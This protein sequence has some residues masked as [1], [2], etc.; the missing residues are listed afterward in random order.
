MSSTL[1]DHARRTGLESL[2]GSPGV[3]GLGGL[4]LTVAA[5]LALF[6]CALTGSAAGV[7][8]AAVVAVV[9]DV[10]SRF[11]PTSPWDLDRP[12]LPPP[13]RWMTS[14]A[15]VLVLA[16]RTGG[17]TGR[18]DAWLV[19]SALATA[20]TAAVLE[21]CAAVTAHLRK[22]PLL[23]RN[24]S[25]GGL[26]V[27]SSPRL[28]VQQGGWLALPLHAL[29]IL[30][31]TL[32]L[33]G[34][35]PEPG[36]LAAVIAV[37]VASAALC[38]WAGGRTLLVLRSGLRQTVPAAVQEA[39]SD[40]G[41]DVILYFGGRPEAL[42]QVEMWLEVMERSRHRVLVLLRDREA[43]RLMRPT[44]LPV[45][46]AE[47]DTVLTALDLGTVRAALYVANG[48]RNIHLLRMGGMRSA[49]IGHGDSDKASSR[50]PFVKVY[51]EVWV[52][53]PAGARRY[54]GEDTRAVSALVR[55][56]GRPQA[57]ASVARERNG[58][59]LTV[60]YAPT[61]EG[62]GEDQDHTSLTRDGAAIVRSL[63]QT[64]G[65]RVVYRPHPLAGT[66]DW[67]ARAA[68][69][70]VVDLMRAAGAPHEAPPRV[71][72]TGAGLDDVDL[73]RT[74]KDPLTTELEES[75]WSAQG[76]ATPRIAEGA[77]PGLASVLDHADL[78]VCDVS[79]VLSDWIARDRP[80][81]VPN[82][83]GMAEE[84]FAERYPSSRAGRVLG[85]EGAGLRDLLE[86]VLRG[87]D[88]TAAARALVRQDLLGPPED[89]DGRFE[90]ALDA[91]T[92]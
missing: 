16:E 89:A 68:H 26:H 23:S 64:P 91:L 60:V 56:V 80:L 51:D 83:G 63:L 18:L 55:E 54:A 17:L 47:A 6:V 86:D 14:V 74:G 61:W 7:L 84:V 9:A 36:A 50:N 73:M 92:D 62:W 71:T 38:A 76:P 4:V 72:D 29:L 31:V 88:P 70:D 10:V 82:V 65:V 11:A 13:W 22:S 90:S 75:F 43:W 69:R 57:L 25:L 39:L 44:T 33:V 35:L 66:R 15:A 27:P 78:L 42:Y 45:V 79:G 19:A 53:G 67:R 37:A 20:A 34:L 8:V 28:L 58:D 52:A 30:S 32:D 5:Y 49:F 12:W 2:P 87:G 81:A 41:P 24:L 21:V 59:P 48:S 46:C 1:A 77:W 3:A 85:A 40:Y